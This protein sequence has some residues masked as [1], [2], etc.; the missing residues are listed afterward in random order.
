MPPHLQARWQRNTLLTL[1]SGYAGYY[2]CRS[3]LSVATPLILDEFE[4]FTK[5]DIGG[6]ASLGVLVY[7]LGKLSNGLLADFFG[8][9]TLFL[10]GMAGSVVCTVLYG[11]GSGLVVFAILWMLNRYFQSMGWVAVVKTASRW[12]PVRRH[13]TVM[14]ILSMS[15]LIGDAL[16]RLY[17]GQAI[18]AGL[19]WRQVFFL[20]AVTL[21]V[22][23]VLVLF[24]L[25]PSPASV[26]VEE[27]HANPRNVFGEQGNQV[28]PDNLMDL[29]RPLLRSRTFWLMCTISFGLT[30]IRETFTFWT[31]TFLHEVAGLGAGA[32][33]VDSLLFPLVGAGSAL[34]AGLLSD[35]LGG[36]HGRILVPALV[37]LVAALVV[38]ASVSLEGR[39]GLALALIS[40]V[41]FFLIGP[42]TLLAGVMS[43]DLGGKKGSST[44]SGMV[45]SAG[46][47]GAVLSGVLVGSLAHR[48]GWSAAF[49]FLTVVCVLTVAVAV[50]YWIHHEREYRRTP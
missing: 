33:A 40:V 20:S 44:T 46:Y 7:A 42:Y 12:F 27:P 24:T 34:V 21:A 47:L 9:R 22:I 4:G 18:N 23:S 28:K 26:G 49:G 11:M 31:P 13:A 2:V 35:R 14:G 8:G 17:L 41:A 1:F 10:L 50:F 3:N 29:L 19:G 32:A 16:T 48:F 15:Y 25:K 43:L 38:L 30:L 37:M 6:I 39:P 5:E 36:R 45:D